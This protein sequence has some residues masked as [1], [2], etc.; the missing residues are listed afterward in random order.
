MKDWGLAEALN[1]GKVMFVT[2]ALSMA[3]ALTQR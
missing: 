3:N 1:G 2:D